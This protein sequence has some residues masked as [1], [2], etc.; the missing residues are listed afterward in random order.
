[1]KI[2]I[3]A[4]ALLLMF[5]I[6]I[7]LA[8]IVSAAEIGPG[9]RYRW[10][11][12]YINSA[13][14]VTKCRIKM[15]NDYLSGTWGTYYTDTVNHWNTLDSR[16]GSSQ[17]KVYAYDVVFSDAKCD[18]YTAATNSFMY[19]N[20]EYNNTIA[21]TIHKNTNGSWSI[22]PITGNENSYF[23]SNNTI[24][25]AAVYF[26]E[27]PSLT[28]EIKY[29]MRHEIGHVL[30]MG[31]ETISDTLMTVWYSGVNTVRQKEIDTLE[32]FYPN[33]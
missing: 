19:T 30:G 1:M 23:P 14:T 25:Y 29:A 3:R 24:T 9:K 11:W 22:D 5:A 7:S 27:V 33:P 31:H 2:V 15:S 20:S 10:N 26:G 21:L 8:N 32:E 17:D 6:I 13:G 28:A 12:T 16:Y 18:M 4:S